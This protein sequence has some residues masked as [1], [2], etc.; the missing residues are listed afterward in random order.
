[1]SKRASRHDKDPRDHETPDEAPE[2]PLDE[3]QPTPVEDPPTA[4]TQ[5]PYVV[6][7]NQRAAHE[8]VEP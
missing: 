8:S 6:R 1:M 7:E 3:P 4:P 2:T 5:A